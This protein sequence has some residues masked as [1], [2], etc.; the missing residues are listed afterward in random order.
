LAFWISLNRLEV[1]FFP[2]PTMVSPPLAVMAWESLR[3]VRP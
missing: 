3:P 2:C 1:I